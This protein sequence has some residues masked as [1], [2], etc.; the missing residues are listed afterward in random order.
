LPKGQ[1]DLKVAKSE[2]PVAT[3]AGCN[4]EQ[5]RAEAE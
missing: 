3:G 4:R 5:L 1:E 2:V